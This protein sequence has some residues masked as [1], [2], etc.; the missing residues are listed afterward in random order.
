MRAIRSCLGLGLLGLGL[1]ASLSGCFGHHTAD[2]E[3]LVA[4]PNISVDG[5]VSDGGAKK[6]GATTGDDCANQTDIFASL[7]CGLGGGTSGTGGIEDL[8]GGL[9]GGGMTGQNCAKLTDPAAQLLCQVTGSG[10][11][12]IEG[13]IGDLL[14]GVLGGGDAGVNG[15]ITDVLV[16][17]I[18]GVIDDLI[19]QL[20]GGGNRDA[21]AGGFLGGLLGGG[22]TGRDAGRG[23]FFGGGQAGNKSLE[24]F[25]SNEQCSSVTADDLLTRLVCARQALETLRPAASDIGAVE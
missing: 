7:L 4:Q 12:G 14:G 20:L 17:V 16:D 10:G 6:D 8:I 9:L 23:G 5:G 1:S 13:L 11:G 22:T 3:V 2:E 19:A 18:G 24:L 21:G 25:R 15:V